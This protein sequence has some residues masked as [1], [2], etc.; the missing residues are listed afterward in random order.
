MNSRALLLA[1]VLSVPVAA[2]AQADTV[3]KTFFTKRDA[4]K[5]G[6][7]L[8]TS[9]VVSVFDKRIA[10]WTQTSSVQGSSS[11]HDLADNLTVVNETPLTIGAFAVYGIGRLAGNET[12]ADVGLHTTEALVTTVAL[13]E[14]IRGPLGRSR[15]RESLDNQYHFKVGRGFTDFAARSYPSIHAAAAFATATSL[16]GELRIRKPGAVP[17]VAPVLYTA[18]LVPGFTRMYLNQ[19]W[20]SDIVAGTFMGAMIGSKV[21]KYAHTHKRNKIDSALL[22]AAVMPDGHGNWL[23]G[24]SFAR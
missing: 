15:P 2:Q 9:A 23:V 5:A 4:V 14:A 19:H 6:A 21:V 10:H 16:V 22:G 3:D 11:R 20:A 18:A 7:I 8:A 1:A 13:A 12:I 17:Y 24:A